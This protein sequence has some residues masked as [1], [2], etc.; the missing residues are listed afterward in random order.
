[1][2]HGGLARGA[3]PL[4]DQGIQC[5]SVELGHVH[6]CHQKGAVAAPGKDQ[7]QGVEGTLGW[8]GLQ[9]QRNPLKFGDEVGMAAV[10]AADRHGGADLTQECSGMGQPAPAAGVG[11]GCFVLAHPPAGAA[12][13]HCS[14]EPHRSHLGT[15]VPQEPL[16]SS[17][18][19][20]NGSQLSPW[21]QVISAINSCY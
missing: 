10:W 14:L 16:E 6:W 17:L 11:K 9:G 2:G 13:E 20:Q 3:P 5:S 21:R 15:M 1:M 12:A 7:L 18:L 4:R 19:L 8:S